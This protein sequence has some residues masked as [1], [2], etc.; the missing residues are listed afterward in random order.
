MNAKASHTKASHT[1]ADPMLARLRRL[2][3]RL[4]IAHLAALV[5]CEA[6]GSLRARELTHL[7]ASMNDGRA[8]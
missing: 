1:K 5:R 3:L 7:L 4:R 6:K 8:G 2:P